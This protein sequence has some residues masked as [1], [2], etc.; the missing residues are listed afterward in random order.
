MA[1]GY[2]KNIAIAVSVA[3]KKKNHV[4][5]SIYTRWYQEAAVTLNFH[6]GGVYVKLK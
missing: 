2:L 1:D 5:Q 4:T 6:E 3:F